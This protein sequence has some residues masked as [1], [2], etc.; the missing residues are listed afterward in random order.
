MSLRSPLGKVLGL[1]VLVLV[2]TWHSQL[3]MRVVVEDYVHA[4]GPKTVTL[5]VLTFSSPPPAS[6]PS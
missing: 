5:I 1:V 4:R 6:S 3:G 2:A